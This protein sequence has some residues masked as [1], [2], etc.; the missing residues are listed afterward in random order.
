MCGCDSESP[1][2]YSLTR[3]KAR[4]PHRCCEC[5]RTIEVGEHYWNLKGLWSDKFEHYHIC[6][7]C[8]D[9]YEEFSAAEPCF[10]Y[11]LTNLISDA[12]DFRAQSG[13]EL[14]SLKSALERVERARNPT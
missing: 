9:L 2:V 10:C 4:K 8:Y 6:S 13:D 12:A 14:P 5:A 1:R 7:Q 11:V 3:P